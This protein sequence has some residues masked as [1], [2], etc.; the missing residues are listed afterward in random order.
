MASG[1]IGVGVIGAALNRGPGTAA[2]TPWATV[3]IIPAVRALP[4]Y[5]LVAVATTK[6]ETAQATA[7]HFGVP[8]AFGNADDLIN[9]GAVDLVVVSV[10]TP[11]HYGLA[12]KALEAGKH[13]FCE[14][15]LGA[16]SGQAETLARLAQEKGVANAVGLQARY[17]PVFQRVRKLVAEGFVGRVLSANLNFAVPTWGDVA[18][19][20]IAYLDDRAN[21]ATL[22]SIYGGHS[23]D[24]LCH[25]LGEL[26][27]VSATV[28]THF[29]EAKV[30]ET[31][32]TIEKTSPDQ[33]G[34]I[35][36]L[37]NG[38]VVSAHFQGGIPT[39]TGCMLEIRG[40]EGALVVASPGIVEVGP[41]TLTGA[42]GRG[43]T[44]EEIAVPATREMPL[45]A[46]N[47]G[48]LLADLAGAIQQGTPFAGPDFQVAL[49]RHRLLDAI[50]R[51]AA[52]GQRQPVA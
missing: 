41:Y 14:W 52:S 25:C 19:K 16:E 29:K 39:L 28:A 43:A 30:V 20:P 9:H 17:A 36:R 47:V 27:E 32:E 11:Y 40:S 23:L 6:Q 42:R 34:V 33:V 21:G 13:V 50:E 12:R 37:E 45:A 18:E 4:E 35:G 31:G 22:L 10:R 44:L 46:A 51:S 48:E 1:K 26:S 49:R 2:H 8:N 24:V 7:D 38:A 5:E 3:A 15:P